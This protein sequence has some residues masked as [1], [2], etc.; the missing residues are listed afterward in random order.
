MAMIK[1]AKLS[2]KVVVAETILECEGCGHKDVGS[3]RECPECGKKMV[4]AYGSEKAG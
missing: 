4:V 3:P 1:R 2:G